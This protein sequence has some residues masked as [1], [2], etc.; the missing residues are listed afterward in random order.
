MLPA[1][2]GLHNRNLLLLNIGGPPPSVAVL[3]MP[4][5]TNLQTVERPGI[6]LFQAHYSADGRW[7][8]IMRGFNTG[9][10]FAPVRDGRLAPESEWKPGVAGETDMYRWSPDAGL[11]Y[12]ISNRDG[13]PCIWA[14]RLNP[15]TKDLIGSPFAVFHAHGAS[16]SMRGFVDPSA[17]GLGVARDRIVFPQ[18]E[19]LGNIWTGKLELH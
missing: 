1:A 9:M 10:S 11:V 19:R 13:F 17:I 7:A 5:G 15:A 8:L 3:S 18:A 14:Q 16:R 4:A 12:F 2:G 6:P